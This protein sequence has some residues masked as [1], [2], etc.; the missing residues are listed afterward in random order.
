MF[1]GHQIKSGQPGLLSSFECMNLAKAAK[2]PFG[3]AG[4]RSRAASAWEST[5]EKTVMEI[6]MNGPYNCKSSQHQCWQMQVWLRGL[7]CLRLVR[8][9]RNTVP[10]QWRR[11]SFLGVSR[12]SCGLGTI[13]DAVASAIFFN[14]PEFWMLLCCNFRNSFHFAEADE[15]HTSDPLNRLTFAYKS[16]KKSG[17]LSGLP[18]CFCDD[19]ASADGRLIMVYHGYSWLI[20]I[21][22]I[23]RFHGASASCGPCCPS[24]SRSMVFCK[25]FRVHIM[26][27]RCFWLTPTKLP[28]SN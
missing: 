23:V 5:G 22:E 27:L 9:N 11:F 18:R 24:A 28:T 7:S 15:P 2:V 20:S 8:R 14:A 25:P 6:S 26:S 3:A 10:S 4:A 19:R 16:Y 21:R 17:V 12:E 13:E 1:G